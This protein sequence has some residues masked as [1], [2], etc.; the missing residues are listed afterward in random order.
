MRLANRHLGRDLALG[1]AGLIAD[2]GEE[3]ADFDIAGHG[4]LVRLVYIPKQEYA[5]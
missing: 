3:A 4:M 2:R 1:Q 5:R